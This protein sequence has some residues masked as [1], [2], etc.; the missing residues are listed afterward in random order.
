[1]TEYLLYTLWEQP[2]I[3][4][5]FLIKIYISGVR[6]LILFKGSSCLKNNVCTGETALFFRQSEHQVVNGSARI[7]FCV[8]ELRVE[9]C[10]IS[11]Q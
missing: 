7:E 5:Y 11:Y 10:D 2:F 9:I 8:C 3:G 4:L 6:L 1:M